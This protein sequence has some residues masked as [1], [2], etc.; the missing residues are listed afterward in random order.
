MI[1]QG[2]ERLSQVSYSTTLTT[3]PIQATVSVE[4]IHLNLFLQD[5]DT[6]FTAPCRQSALLPETPV[7]YSVRV[8]SAETSKIMS[9]RL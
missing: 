3:H 9:D 5:V 6:S 7:C 2:F 4:V 1:L 8:L